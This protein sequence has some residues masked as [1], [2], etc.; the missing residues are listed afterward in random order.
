MGF[1]WS[2][3]IQMYTSIYG[4]HHVKPRG[5]SVIH[6]AV[7]KRRLFLYSRSLKVHTVVRTPSTHTISTGVMATFVALWPLMYQLPAITPEAVAHYKTRSKRY[8]DICTFNSGSEPEPKC[9][10]LRLIDIALANEITVSEKT[11]VVRFECYHDRNRNASCRWT[12][13][14]GGLK[15]G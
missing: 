6:L 11:A 13:S 9:T 10:A 14:D 8:P 5:T 12:I 1:G 3:A 4:G 2:V 15:E 7:S